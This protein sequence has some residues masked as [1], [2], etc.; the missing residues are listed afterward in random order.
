MIIRAFRG[1]PWRRACDWGV[2]FTLKR[3]MI[4]SD[5]DNDHHYCHYSVKWLTEGRRILKRCAR[6]VPLM[7][8]IH[9]KEKWKWSIQG[10]YVRHYSKTWKNAIFFAIRAERGCKVILS[11]QPW[12]HSVIWCIDHRLISNSIPWN[13]YTTFNLIFIYPHPHCF[14]SPIFCFYFLHFC[15]VLFL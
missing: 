3:P 6:S 11:F 10:I 13:I 7:L 12:C 8:W 2:I 5:C 9:Y 4:G 15:P 1:R 14:L